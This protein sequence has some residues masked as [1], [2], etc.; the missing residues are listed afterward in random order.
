M[1]DD[2]NGAIIHKSKYKSRQNRPLGFGQ[3]L[4]NQSSK[5]DAVRYRFTILHPRGQIDKQ[6]GQMV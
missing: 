6:C 2:E 5:I 1:I 3:I 4:K